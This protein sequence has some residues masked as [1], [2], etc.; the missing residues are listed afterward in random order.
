MM[1][2]GPEWACDTVEAPLS[3]EGTETAAE[4]SEVDPGG[5]S[6]VPTALGVLK[7]LDVLVEWLRSIFISVHAMR[8]GFSYSRDAQML[9]H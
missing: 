1:D 9:V 5:S 7:L 2:A 4:S 3:T 6:G 8:L